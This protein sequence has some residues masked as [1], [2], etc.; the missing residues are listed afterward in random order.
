MNPIQVTKELSNVNSQK[1]HRQ[2]QKIHGE[3]S[4][5]P[6]GTRLG[7]KGAYISVTVSLTSHFMKV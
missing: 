1:G 4:T 2:F 5:T 7:N 6:K 3:P